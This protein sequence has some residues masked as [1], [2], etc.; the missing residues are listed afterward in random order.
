MTKRDRKRI[1]QLEAALRYIAKQTAGHDELSKIGGLHK[2]AADILT[3]SLCMIAVR[4]CN[5]AAV[6]GMDYNTIYS[7]C[8]TEFT[9][10]EIAED[11]FMKLDCA[12][13]WPKGN[14]RYRI[15]EIDGSIPVD[16]ITG[17]PL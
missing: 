10:R 8:P 7:G 16:V 14:P 11:W 5:T 1:A 4:V 9:G 17:K 2:V 6:A 13:T 15:V 12:P 3:G